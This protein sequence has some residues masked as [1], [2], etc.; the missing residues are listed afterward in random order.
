MSQ[1][2]IKQIEKKTKHL[3]A[4]KDNTEMASK[5]IKRCSMLQATREMQMKTRDPRAHLLEWLES[6]KQRQNSD[7]E[8]EQ[9]TLPA[10][11]RQGSRAPQHSSLEG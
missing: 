2:S 11:A 5:H 8:A 1:N 9:L 7:K 10:T 3:N 4:R 6:R